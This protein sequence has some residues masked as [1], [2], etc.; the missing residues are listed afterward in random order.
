MSTETATT[1]LKLLVHATRSYEHTLE[2]ALRPALDERLRP[3]HFAVFR[4]LDPEGSRITALAEAAGMTQQSMGEL[5]T[6]LE[7]CGYVERRVD[8]ADRRARLVVATPA[9]RSALR[10]ARRE[11]EAIERALAARLGESTVAGLRAALAGVADVLG[12]G[13]R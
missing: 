10:R 1:L 7:A 12:E 9:G 8:P 11:I 5:V 4:Y 3:A 13:A 6:H 2:Q